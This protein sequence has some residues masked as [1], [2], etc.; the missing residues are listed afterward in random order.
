MGKF[1]TVNPFMFFSDGSFRS[2]RPCPHSV[3]PK[4]RSSRWSQ[5]GPAPRGDLTLLAGHENSAS[6]PPNSKCTSG[7]VNYFPL[8]SV[9]KYRQQREFRLTL[10]CI[11]GPTYPLTVCIGGFTGVSFVEWKQHKYN[12][13]PKQKDTLNNVSCNVRKIILFTETRFWNIPIFGLLIPTYTY[14]NSTENKQPHDT[15]IGN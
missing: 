14:S 2:L 6:S 8:F 13:P 11:C 9:R 5:P 4:V 15:K 12:E 3:P 7:K 10:I 1:A